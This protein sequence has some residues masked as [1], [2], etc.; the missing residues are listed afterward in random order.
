MVNFTERRIH[1]HALIL[2]LLK[3]LVLLLLGGMEELE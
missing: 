1:F 2:Y 3:V